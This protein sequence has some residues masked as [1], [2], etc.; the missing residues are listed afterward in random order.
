V[1]AI[2]F[3][4]KNP[5]NPVTHAL[6]IGVSKYAHLPG[7]GGKKFPNHGGMGQL[8][9]PAHSARAFA[10]WLLEEYNHPDKPLGSVSLLIS[11]STS[12]PFQFTIGGKKKTVKPERATM[13]FVKPAVKGWRLLG[14]QNPQNLLLFYFCGHGIAAGS[15][16]ALLLEDFGEDPLAPLDGAIDFR[17]LNMNMDECVAREHCYFIDAC[18]VG[19]DMLI[20]NSGFAGQPIIQNSGLPGNHAELRKAPVFFS[21][22]AG[23][24][25]FAQK[26]E[27]SIFAKA[28][29]QSLKGLGSGD[30]DGPWRVK[31]T[32]IHDALHYLMQE[33]SV[34]LK[35]NQAQIPMSDG[36]TQI[37]MN[38]VPDPQDIP[39]MV[40]I[41]PAEANMKATLKC[42][43][44]KVHLKR[45]PSKLPWRLNLP[46]GDY[47][48]KAEF[49]TA[50]YKPNQTNQRIKPPYKTVG[51]LKV[52]L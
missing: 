41:D 52:S 31:T 20:K 13:K 1:S 45:K 3:E 8:S 46:V 15:D 16:L 25:A 50:E 51:P 18:R 42:E 23:Q 47:D 30:E 11:E 43:N 22:L 21:T 33:E 44:S 29:L 40:I 19:S 24:L 12:K 39:V 27:P 6:V 34:R 28:L 14:D 49:K 37:F 26:G 32:R 9:S 7:G 5:A 48:F 10:K 4:K 35:L 17:R 36:L 2:I 38:I